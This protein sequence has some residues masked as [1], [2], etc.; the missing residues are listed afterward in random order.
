MLM[1]EV[2]RLEARW[3]RGC[4]LAGCLQLMFA[5]SGKSHCFTRSLPQAAARD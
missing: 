4:Y 2:T 5:A 1:S 3:H